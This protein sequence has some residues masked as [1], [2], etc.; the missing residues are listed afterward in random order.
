M[1]AVYN[2]PEFLTQRNDFFTVDVIREELEI[3][4]RKWVVLEDD[5]SL[6]RILNA[7]LGD[8]PGTPMN[9]SA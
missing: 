3:Y 6:I 8:A 9:G 1:D 4:D 5:F 7:A 2:I